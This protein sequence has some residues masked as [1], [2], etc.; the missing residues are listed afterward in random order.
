MAAPS[1]PGVCGIGRQQAERRIL[2]A[3][4]N[5]EIREMKKRAQE[6]SQKKK[7]GAKKSKK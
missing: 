6:K 7:K 1:P 5:E 4:L 2:R 3:F